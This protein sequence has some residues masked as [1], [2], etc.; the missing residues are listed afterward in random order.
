ME[1]PRRAF[2]LIELLVVIAIVAVLAVVV[3][4]VLNPAQLL[5]QARDATRVSDMA[6]LSA[7]ISLYKSDQQGATSYTLG[8]STV[9]Y[10]S[11]PAADSACASLGLPSSSLWAYACSTSANYRTPSSSGW[12]PVNFQ[13]IDG[14]SPFGALPVDP[15]N[16]TSS[17]LYY[18]YETDGAHYTLSAFMESQKYAKTMASTG[19]ADPA[20]Y[21]VGTGINT[22]PEAGRG[23]VGYW[24]LNEGSG[25]SAIDWSGNGNNGTLSGGA[26]YYSPGKTEQWA[27]SFN[28]SSAYISVPDNASLDPSSSITVAGWFYFTTDTTQSVYYPVAKEGSS[29]GGWA[30]GLQGTYTNCGSGKNGTFYAYLNQGILCASSPS[31]LN[32]WYF[33]AFTYDN[34]TSNLYINGTLVGRSTSLTMTSNASMPLNIGRRSDAT[35]Y[36]PGYIQDVRFYG[37]ALS[38]AEIQQIYNAE[39]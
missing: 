32:T 27:G 11:V 26:G 1:N 12:L 2:T 13:N 25:S 36:W 16:Q 18:T 19:G 5:A 4:L 23:L 38:A 24:P 10:I 37:R 22:L 28:G 39:K 33:V 3:T 35:W 8:T 30:L 21:E 14:G 15:V 9:A 29:G 34:G 20:L 31:S 6:T 7:G 17:N